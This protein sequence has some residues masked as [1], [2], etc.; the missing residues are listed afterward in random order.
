[1]E[2]DYGLTLVSSGT[3]CHLYDISRNLHLSDVVGPIFPCIY[4]NIF[5]LVF[6]AFYRFPALSHD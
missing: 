5:I 1:M 2:G 6:V 3:L 4:E